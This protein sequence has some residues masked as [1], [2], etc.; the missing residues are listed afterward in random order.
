ME[1]KGHP[2]TGVAT[3][4]WVGQR[5]DLNALVG[6][7]FTDWLTA[8]L[9]VTGVSK[10]LPDDY[11]KD[12]SFR[13]LQQMIATNRILE[14]QTS[15]LHGQADRARIPADLDAQILGFLAEHPK[16]SWT[17][18][19][20]KIVGDHVDRAEKRRRKADRRW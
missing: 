8:R 18:A 17:Q 9:A 19:M 11:V 4:Y 10:L 7:T 6:T 5:V 16:W 1:T 20:E 2:K 12:R 15:E 3:P 13:R 14:A